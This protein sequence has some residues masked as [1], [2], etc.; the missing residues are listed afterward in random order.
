MKWLYFR[1]TARV[2]FSEPRHY[3]YV[4]IFLISVIKRTIKQTVEGGEQRDGRNVHSNETEVKR[5]N[6]EDLSVPT[7]ENAISKGENRFFS[8]I[9]L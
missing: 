4:C 9:S 5:I 1:C 6:S 3:P 8:L 2:S 7:F